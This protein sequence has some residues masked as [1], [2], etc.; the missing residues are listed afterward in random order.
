M[1]RKDGLASGYGKMEWYWGDT[2]VGEF[3]KE[4]LM[5]KVNGLEHSREKSRSA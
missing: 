2:Y 3:L 4:N 1:E 5:V